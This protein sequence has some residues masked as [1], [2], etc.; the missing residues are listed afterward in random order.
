MRCYGAVDTISVLQQ[1][2]GI[3]LVEAPST[4]AVADDLAPKGVFECARQHLDLVTH[5]AQWIFEEIGMMHAI[6][7]GE[8]DD[9]RRIPRVEVHTDLTHGACEDVATK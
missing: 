1:D 6:I 7:P 4:G 2:A 5:D 3:Y 8:R 9:R